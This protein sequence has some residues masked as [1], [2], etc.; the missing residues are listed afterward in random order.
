[1]RSIAVLTSARGLGVCL[2]L[3]AC[4]HDMGQMKKDEALNAYR[5]AIRW[6]AFE[7]ARAQ[8]SGQAQGHKVSDELSDVHVTGYDVVSSQQARDTESLHQ[9]VAIR[10]YR[11]GDVVER[12]VMD[13]Q[14]WRYDEEKGQWVIDSPLPRFK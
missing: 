4:A 11:D 14:S 6:G 13:D 1:L 2:V 7:L 8:Q 5:T 9:R 3:S 10:Y 12:T